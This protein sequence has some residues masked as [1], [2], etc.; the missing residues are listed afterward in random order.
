M[1][2]N[3]IKAGQWIFTEDGVPEYFIY[4]LMKGRVSIYK[5]GRKIREVEIMDGKK[6]I[7]LGITAVLREDRMHKASVKAETDV[8][9]GS[10]PVEQI[11]GVLANE[12]PAEIKKE[13]EIMTQAISL[14]NE[15]VSSL[16]KFNDLPE[17][18]L[19]IPEG[20]TSQTT[21]ILSEIKRLYGLITQ[22]V[23]QLSK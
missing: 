4:K 22:D 13:T 6:P 8:E 5:S 23:R 1:D 11:R 15:I 14:G 7:L 17:V 16:S 20:L 21:E 12:V 18:D 2:I 3:T 9:V 19:D 10:V